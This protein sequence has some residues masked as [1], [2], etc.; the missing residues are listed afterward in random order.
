M[1]NSFN[2]DLKNEALVFLYESNCAVH[3]TKFC[4]EKSDILL[5]RDINLNARFV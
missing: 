2:Q 5:V 4:S 1:E 3:C